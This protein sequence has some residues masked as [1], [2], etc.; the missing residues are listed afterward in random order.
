MKQISSKC[1]RLIKINV[2]SCLHLMGWQ[3]SGVAKEWQQ[4]VFQASSVL[5]FLFLF[6][7]QGPFQ[8][9]DEENVRRAHLGDC[10]RS[11]RKWCILFPT[12]IPLQEFRP[13]HISLQ[14]RLK[15]FIV[16]KNKSKTLAV[17]AAGTCYYLCF[18]DEETHTQKDSNKFRKVTDLGKIQPQVC[19]TTKSMLFLGNTTELTGNCHHL[20]ILTSV[21]GLSKWSGA[22]KG[23]N[24]LSSLT[25]TRGQG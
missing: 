2:I 23:L 13:G 3:R 11:S 12:S 21:G 6:G 25:I 22:D 19:R 24:C 14:E 4:A 20:S 9:A 7:L 8:S 5:K 16:P 15:V 1:Q 17:P 18:T 10:Y